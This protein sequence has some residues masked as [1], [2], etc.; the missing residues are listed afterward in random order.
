MHNLPK[1]VG[2]QAAR[3]KYLSRYYEMEYWCPCII[4]V[5]YYAGAFEL[6]YSILYVIS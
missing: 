5:L 4:I 1:E 3:L 2:T 6:L